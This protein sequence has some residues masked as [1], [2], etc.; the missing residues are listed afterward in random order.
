MSAGNGGRGDGPDD[1]DLDD[2]D[3][4]DAGS[5]GGGTRP[6]GYGSPPKSGQFRKGKSGNPKGRPRT[7][8]ADE[9]LVPAPARY[10][11]HEH[12]RAEADRRIVVTDATGRKTI[13]VR[14]GILRTRSLRALQGS[15]LAQ[16]DSLRDFAQEDERVHQQHKKSFEYW[17]EYQNEGR[18]KIAM[19]MKRGEAPPDL[20]PHPEDIHLDWARLEVQIIGAVDEAERARERKAET[21]RAVAYEMSFYVDED[22]RLPSEGDTAG[23]VGIYM[24]LYLLASTSLPARLRGMPAEYDLIILASFR[25]RRSWGVDLERRCKEVRIPFLRPRKGVAAKVF[26]A[27]KLGFKWDKGEVRFEL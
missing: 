21:L 2:N 12:L 4:D 11:T 23:G 22:N 8:Q 17:H 9:L 13:T 16:R 24:A 1:T 20:L 18:A 19:A 5:G 15:V 10:P 26:P 3:R 6:I 25:N 27:T 14:E 7:Q